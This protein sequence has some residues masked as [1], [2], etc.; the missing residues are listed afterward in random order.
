MDL[1]PNKPSQTP[2]RLQ[3]LWYYLLALIILTIGI[4]FM[5]SGITLFF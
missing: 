2:T 3:K 1:N 5:L 4:Y